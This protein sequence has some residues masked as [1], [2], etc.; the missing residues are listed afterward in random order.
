MDLRE[1]EQHKF[2]IAEVLRS[3]SPAAP[4]E[5]RDWH[6]QAQ[7]L[8]ARLADDRF[9]LVVIGRFNRGKTSLMNAI[10]GTDRLPTGILP[11]TSVIT[12]ISYGSK[13]QVV[14]N[15]GGRIL[16]QEISIDALPRYIT[17]EG[18]PANV[19]RIRKAEVQLPAEI[20]RRGFHFVDTPGLG[21]AITENTRTT[22]E[23]LPEADA[24]LLVTSYESPLSDEEMRFFRV[25]SSSARRIFIVLNKHDTVTPDERR[26][27]LAYVREQ[28]AP[29]FDQQEPRIFSVSARDGIEAKR[30]KD[31]VRLDASGLPALESELVGFLLKEKSAEFLLRMCDRTAQLVQELGTPS[32]AKLTEEIGALT[33]QIVHDS[34]GVRAWREASEGLPA[35]LAILQR[36]RP[37]EVCAQIGQG[38]WDFLRRFQYE[39]SIS[40]DEQQRF[41]K[42]GGFC[43]FHTWQYESISSPLGTCTGFP[44]LLDRLAEQLRCRAQAALQDRA[45]YDEIEDL[46]PARHGCVLCAVQAKAEAE[47]ISAIANRLSKDARS[48]HRLSAI[49]LPHLAMVTEAIEDAGLIRKLIE[50]EALILERVSEDMKRYALKR[51]AVR[52][53]LLSDDETA[54]AHRALLL[55]AGHRNVNAT[56]RITSASLSNSASPPSNRAS[57]DGSGASA[58]ALRQ[59][60]DAAPH[61]DGRNKACR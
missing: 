21:S 4:S 54:A 35:G 40:H 19:Q 49:C 1:Y 30:S 9:N 61:D 60:L 6:E 25:A 51:D 36:L 59:L 39:L 50:R 58:D 5:Q 15:Y 42:R 2:A 56:S 45:L 7:E 10:M 47:A 20:L 22:E 53:S 29:I 57:A 52:R 26:T 32:D 12:T 23:F 28:L 46:V 18:N 38:V 41:A 44:P 14:L 3:A 43:A 31:P 11:L 13:E 48:L 34:R 55:L 37:C 17:Q 24:F 16:S 8:F 27:A 33:R